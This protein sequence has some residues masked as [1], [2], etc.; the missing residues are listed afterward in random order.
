[1]ETEL[2]AHVALGVIGMNGLPV[3]V[4]RRFTAEDAEHAESAE[5]PLVCSALLV[6][7]RAVLDAV[8]WLWFRIR[9]SS[10]RAHSLPP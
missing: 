2:G 9:Q 8:V 6:V 4:G 1:M 10:P 5:K 7:T 3:T